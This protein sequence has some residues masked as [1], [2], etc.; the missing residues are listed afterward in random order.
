MKFHVKLCTHGRLGNEVGELDDVAG[1][2]VD[3]R[4][5]PLVLIVV[6]HLNNVRQCQ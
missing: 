1:V 4:L 5:E 3:E 6:L 2:G